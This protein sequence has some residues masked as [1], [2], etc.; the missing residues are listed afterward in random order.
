M[1]EVPPGFEMSFRWTADASSYGALV[2]TFRYGWDISDFNDP[3]QWST[4][5]NPEARRADAKTFYSGTHMLYIESVDN[6]GVSTFGCIEVTVIPVVLERDLMWVDDYRS[7]RRLY[8][9]DIRPADRKE[10]DEFWTNI[11]LRVPDFV[12]QR[13]IFDCAANVFSPPPMS[14][15]FQYKNI[16]WTYSSR[17]PITRGR[18]GRY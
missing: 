10:H 12:P 5:P 13:D 7:H 14:R 11:C 16:I 1:V 8:P 17:P 6:L 9:N 4:L 18:H 15:V 2:S 3:A